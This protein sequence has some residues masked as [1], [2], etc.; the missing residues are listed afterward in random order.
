VIIHDGVAG[1]GSYEGEKSLDLRGHYI[2]PSF[3]DGHLDVESSM[4][5]VPES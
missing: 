3:I 4:L 5:S 2:Y 1:T